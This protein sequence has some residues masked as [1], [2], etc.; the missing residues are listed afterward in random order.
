MAAAAT[1][2][3]LRLCQGGDMEGVKSMLDA[4]ESIL[5]CRDAQ[6]ASGLHR[7]AREGHTEMLQVLLE[8][9]LGANSVDQKMVTALHEACS[10]GRLDCAKILLGR[11]AGTDRHKAN[12]S[13]Q[14]GGFT[15]L[16]CA[17]SHGHLELAELLIEHGASVTGRDRAG[18]CPLSSAVRSSNDK[19]VSLLLSKGA[20]P[21]L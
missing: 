3:F 10:N 16:H 14:T 5:G 12:S 9:G 8:R 17:C 13:L 15:P 20:L 21:S 4:D 11:G 2:K 7:A 18:E 6:G 1:K 19:L